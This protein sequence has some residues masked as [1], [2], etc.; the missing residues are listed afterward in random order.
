MRIKTK[1]PSITN[2]ATTTALSAVVKN[3]TSNVSN[4]VQKTDYNTKTSEIEK[5]ITD[6]DHDEY[7]INSEFNVLTPEHFAAKLAQSNLASKN[8]IANFVKKTNFDDKLKGLNKK[9]TSNK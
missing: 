9:I 7:I 6:H 5:N 8:D 3:K 2:L 4:L 1:Y